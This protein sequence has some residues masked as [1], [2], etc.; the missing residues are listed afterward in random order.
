MI[1]LLFGAL[2]AF[3][4]GSSPLANPDE[5]RYAEIPREMIATGDWVTPRLDGVNY[6]EKPPL[7]YWTVALCLEAFGSS[8]WALRLT[9]AVCALGGVLLTYAAARRF[10]GVGAGRAAAG[11]LGTSVLYFGAGRFLALDLMVSVLMTA[12]LVCFILAL[13]EPAG[14]RRRWLFYG[15][16]TSAALATLTKG[17]IGFL[18][19]GA[20]MFFW[21]LVFKQ[22]R[23]LRPLYLPTGALLFLAIALPWH[24]LAAARNETWAHRYIVFEH[25][26]RFTTTQ[27]GRVQ[28]WHF[29]I[30]ILL[31]GMFPWSGFLWGAVRDA[32]RGGWARRDEN[33]TAWF[34]VTWALF[35]LGFFSLSGSKLP[36]YIL[37]IFPA[38]AVLVGKQIAGA[39]ARG[40]SG[41]RFGFG[42]FAFGCGVLAVGAALAA[43]KP[44][45]IHTAEQAAA[46]RP[47]A[48]VLA[49]S[50]FT[51]GIAA[52]WLAKS[53][54]VRAGLVAMIATMLVFF[55]VLAM[56]RTDIQ[57]VGTKALAM[58]FLAE[59]QPGER[60]IHFGEFFHDFTF[61][62]HRLVDV[63]GAQSE[64]EL[65]EDPGAAG[66][67]RFY[68]EATLRKYWA[69]P[70]RVWLVLEKES[71]PKLTA[72]A[73]F[74]Y[75]LRGETR[76][77]Y[78]LSN[79][80]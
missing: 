73:A 63:V 79:R 42:G 74:H 31:G 61:Y 70:E 45:V 57:R 27:H 32:V 30:W 9:P 11:V 21:L 1:G 38:L 29:F 5:G 15:L 36:P 77:H 53:R 17:F 55:G 8:E 20:V 6:F 13:D 26:E 10:Y 67:G 2:F 66:S 69:G 68:D 76:N 49:A 52:A 3:R 23:R 28:P 72:D 40:G 50:F 60:V 58:K 44:G 46:L 47:F 18:V 78:L 16:Y 51:G 37:P 7:M 19:T 33:A 22:W 62:T 48:L 24:L 43:L 64:L 71:L 12:T 39:L 41:L 4:L 80:P 75:R 54:G 25:W 56:A 34:F 59:A 35:V 65:E 14:T